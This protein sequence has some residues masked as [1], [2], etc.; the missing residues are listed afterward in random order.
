MLVDI[1]K[2]IELLR[3]AQDI[4]IIP[5]QK[6]DG[7]TLSCALALYL[8]LTKLGKQ[9]KIECSDAIPCKYNYMFD[10]VAFSQEFEP[11]FVITVDLADVHLFG[12]KMSLY[13]DKT[14]L[15]I[16][17]HIS[18]TDF[19]THTFLDTTAAAT[20]EIIYDVLCELGVEIDEKIATAIYTG[21]C[22]DTG[23]FKYSNTTAQSHMIAADLISKK[24]PYAFINR[25]MF[26]T[27]SAKRIQAETLIMNT[28]EY[29]CDK[30]CAVMVI[31]DETLKTAGVTEQDLE[32]V[33]NL[34]RQIEGVEVGVTIV[35]RAES[36]Y[37][38]SMRTNEHINACEVC[39]KFG[40]GG[41]IRASG[42]TINGDLEQVKDKIISVLEDEFEQDNFQSK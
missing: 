15:C 4:L 11:K 8:A 42:C 21:I 5:H 27:K 29:Y 28:L 20:A 32:G 16:D 30:K 10:G 33:S 3:N 26:D 1:K 37:K 24:I 2:T 34:P 38:V 25:I 39:K 14:D 40:G 41:H 13:A 12:E 18:N 22:T 31:T 19:A 35:Q 7:D 9:A 17:H 6:P 36:V 23:C